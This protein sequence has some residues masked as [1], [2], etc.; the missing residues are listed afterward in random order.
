LLIEE[1][2][3]I[4]ADQTP[5][6]TD[7]QLQKYFEVGVSHFIFRKN[8]RT[9]TTVKVQKKR[10]TKKL[11]GRL[12]QC[13]CADFPWNE[14]YKRSVMS[15]YQKLQQRLRQG[16]SW[17]ADRSNNGFHAHN[18]ANNDAGHNSARQKT[19]SFVCPAT[20]FSES[21]TDF[22]RVVH[23]VQDGKT[24]M[25]LNGQDHDLYFTLEGLVSVKD[26]ATI[27]SKLMHKLVADDDVLFLN[28]L[29]TWS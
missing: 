20:S 10:E 17:S 23:M 5:I 25:A 22:E 12:A 16:F 9:H 28:R 2:Q 15:C 3:A 6:P 27:G 7:S 19:N 24:Y 1:L 4:V 29:L 11:A 18:Q 21:S 26:A 13:I 8:V 14:E